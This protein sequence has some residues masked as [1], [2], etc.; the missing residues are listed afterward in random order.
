MPNPQILKTSVR[1]LVE[2]VLK[3]GDLHT[4][5]F[6]MRNR[7]VAGTWGHQHVQKGRP[8]GYE[9]EVSI[10]HLVET[11]QLHL[12]IFGRI[13]GIFA[14]EVPPIIDEIKTTTQPLPLITENHNPLHWAQA[15]CYA[16]IYALQNNLEEIGIQLT[17]YQ[18]DTRQTKTFQRTLSLETLTRFF[19]ELVTP[20][21]QWAQTLIDWQTTRDQTIKTFEFPYTNYRPGQR[22]MAV[23][24]Y[25][26]IYA[27][28]KFFIQAPT[29]VGKTIA[30]LFPAVKAI[31]TGLISKI[32]YLTAKTPGRTVAEK[33][34]DDMRQ[35]GLQL[36]SV[37]LTAKDKICFCTESGIDPAEC[38]F[39]KN[40]Y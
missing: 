36:R 29:G 17:Y 31:G 25:K 33:A 21:L 38:E 20:Y 5:G 15:T 8:E 6:Q 4:G 1:S 27:K 34:I 30:T 11:D 19:D 7:A 22:E 35:A 14:Q 28:K 24:V 3:E 9:A 39:T 23:E 37:T 32:F 2:F 26:T 16:Y 10:K 40:Y 12:E 18:L 13:D